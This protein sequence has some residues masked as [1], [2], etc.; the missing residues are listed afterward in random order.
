MLQRC[1][2]AL[3]AADTSLVMLTP[4]SR[5]A[6]LSARL[7]ALCDLAAALGHSSNVPDSVGLLVGHVL[8][9]PLLY[10]PKSLRPLVQ[11][12]PA[13]GPAAA[14]ALREAATTALRQAL[15]TPERSADDQTLD[16]IEWVCRCADCNAVIRWAESAQAL[17]LTLAM[18]EYRRRHVQ[19]SLSAAAA[20]LVCTTLRQGSPHK[21]VVGKASGLREIRREL[22]RTW[23]AD[24]SAMVGG[25]AV[26][27][28][29]S[30]ARGGRSTRPTESR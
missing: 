17:A 23:E 28:E 5:S 11:A 9:H 1:Q 20:P 30:P 16:G 29:V 15:S 6:S 10:P 26:P 13:G 7:Q 27:P 25:D 14:Q 2:E 21:L 22:R 18:P 8:A 24:L 12:L 3:V 19:K 4:A